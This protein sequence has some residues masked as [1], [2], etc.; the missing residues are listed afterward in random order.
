[1]ETQAG[2]LDPTC[3]R[4]GY[5]QSGEAATWEKVCPI[6]GTCP[7]CGH[8]FGWADLY[9]PSRQDVVWSVESGETRLARL[10]KTPGMAAR[11]VLP[12]VYWK[13]AG[14][15]MP[16]RIGRLWSWLVWVTLAFQAIAWP[17][18]FLGLGLIT[19]GNWPPTL[20]DIGDVFEV[21]TFAELAGLAVDGIGWPIMGVGPDWSGPRFSLYVLN[22]GAGVVL[23]FVFGMCVTW[24]VVLF[25]IPATRR[26]VKLRPAHIAR[27]ALL[28][29]SILIPLYMMIR[30][31]LLIEHFSFG[32]LVRSIIMYVT[33]GAVF[34]AVI[35]WVSALRVGWNIRSWVLVVLG[36]LAALLGGLVAIFIE[37]S[38]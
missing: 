32:T 28:Q 30:V 20:G 27:A 17:F 5:D 10:L 13:R 3:P 22:I 19:L 25:A 36:T 37:D 2:Y 29:L 11:M 1:M 4:C 14:V 35:W 16:L 6:E 12:W 8:G 23:R 26:L 18:V 38:L 34:W 7:E 15:D 31:G 21:L 33:L 24:C 9:N